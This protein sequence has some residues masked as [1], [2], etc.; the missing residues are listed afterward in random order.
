MCTSLQVKYFDSIG[1]RENHCLYGKEKSEGEN[2]DLT[3]PVPKLPQ[4]VGDLVEAES[5]PRV[6]TLDA[7]SQGSVFLREFCW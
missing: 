6:N 4:K 7:R 1:F 2:L 3:P 5:E